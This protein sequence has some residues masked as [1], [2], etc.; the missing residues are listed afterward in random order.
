MTTA[1][2]PTVTPTGTPTT[3]QTGA[4]T[5]ARTD[6][7]TG[8]APTTE[9]RDARS[10]RII[11]WLC[12]GLFDIG[13]TL[14]LFNVARQ[15]GVSEFNAYLLSMI[16]PL[17]S[18]AV[19]FVRHRKLSMFSV[20]IL[21]IQVIAALITFIGSTDP[22]VLILKDSA[23]TAGI[24]LIF[25]T[26]TLVAKPA[27]FYLGQKFSPEGAGE[28][29]RMWVQYPGFRRTQKI[30][31]FGWALAFL[32]EAAIRVVAVYT[33]PFDAAFNLG[34]VLPIVVIGLTIAWTI[35]LARRARRQ[36][37]VAHERQAAAQSPTT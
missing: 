29:D 14:L 37:A 2:D 24:G 26:S 8:T 4:Q 5:D 10:D 21:S 20:F 32:L 25:L 3:T 23:L 36:G 15:N 13:L 17:V 31:G 27:T 28:W 1:D 16:G 35:W 11:S 19:E 18:I 12:M 7:Q 30:V 9:A 33:L 6:A 34:T 22:K